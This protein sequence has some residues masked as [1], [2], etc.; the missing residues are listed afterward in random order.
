[1]D[2]KYMK[3]ALELAEKGKGHTSPNPMVGAVI[4]K[5]GRI[6]GEGYHEKVGE[7]HAEVNAISSATE[8]VEGATI[9]VTLEPCS[10]YGKTPPCSNLI[11]EKKLK[12]VV[13][14]ATDPNPLVSGSGLER[15]RKA[16][17]EV[18]EGV[19]EEESNR[20][21]E[22]FI[23]YIT[24]KTPFVVMKYAMSLDGKIATET[25]DSKWISSEESRAHAHHLRG[26][27]SG[28]MAGI[29]TVLEDDPKLTCR[30]PGYHNPIRIILDSKLRVPLD[31]QALSDQ[32]KAP[33][34]ILTTD[35]SSVVKR[36]QLTDLGVQVL[37]VPERNGQVELKN[38][39]VLLGE[40]GIDSILLEGGGTL[41]AA[42]LEA[43]IIDK[44][45]IYVAPKLIGGKDAVSPVM[46]QGV[47]KMNEA[48]SI[49]DMQV[50]KINE[51]LLIEGYTQEE[52]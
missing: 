50:T 8:S 28:I 47:E 31:A 25:G 49:R 33:T 45:N 23:K 43:G 11:I 17:I 19:L 35:D 37:V 5:D 22:V 36:R 14:A 39:M 34:L 15:L 1:M 41:N 21:N 13:V 29:G 26:Y 16:G 48:F 18:V 2:I 10:H 7:A 24:T 4:V 32:D 20:L 3:R 44:V 38:A 52:R 30:V 46:G 6:I 27:L 9:Y 12:K 40:K 42:A 51:D